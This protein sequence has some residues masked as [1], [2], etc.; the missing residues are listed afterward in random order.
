[1]GAKALLVSLNDP[2]EQSKVLLQEGYCTFFAGNRGVKWKEG[3]SGDAAADTTPLLK[4]GGMTKSDPLPLRELRLLLL[5][6]GGSDLERK[7][8]L[9]LLSPESEAPPP[10]A[11]RPLPLPLPLL[12]VPPVWTLFSE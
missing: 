5:L 3:V 6:L 4:P 8:S 9:Q 10:I 1:M 12:L 2:D 11:P 7:G